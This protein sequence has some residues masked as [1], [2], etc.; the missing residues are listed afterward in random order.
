MVRQPLFGLG[1]VNMS[2]DNVAAADLSQ[3]TEYEIRK[4]M[5]LLMVYPREIKNRQEDEFV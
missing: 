1:S 5:L 4:P 2:E 3:T